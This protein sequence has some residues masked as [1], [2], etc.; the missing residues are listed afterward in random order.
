MPAEERVQHDTVIVVAGGGLV[1]AGSVSLPARRVVV[2]ADGGVDLALALGLS[3]DLAVGD[4]DSAS[5]SGLATVEASGARVVR[6]PPEKDATD[7]ELALDEA[8]ALGSRRLV[9]VGVESGRLDHLLAALL[10]LGAERYAA[11]EVDALF[12]GA[13]AHLVREERRLAGEPGELVSL[14]ALH[15]PAEGVVTEG[16]AYALRRETLLPGSSRGVSNVFAARE[17]RISLE[18]GVLL[19]LRP[20]PEQTE[21]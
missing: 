11:F 19:A 9:V 2:A 4:F 13:T 14:L 5:P 3:V 8:A 21:T 16:L 12:G 6:H 15:G 18:R 7:L 1:P 10:L 20:G 17:A